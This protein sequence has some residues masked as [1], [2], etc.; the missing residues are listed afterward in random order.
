MCIIKNRDTDYLAWDAC[1][2]PSVQYVVCVWLTI[3]PMAPTERCRKKDINFRTSPASPFFPPS[4]LII[5]DISCTRCRLD[6]AFAQLLMF[7]CRCECCFFRN[8]LVSAPP[9]IRGKCCTFRV[10]SFWSGFSVF[11]WILFWTFVY[12][13]ANPIIVFFC[14]ITL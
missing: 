10:T 5:V 12:T 6:H 3:L 1:S 2:M 4:A 8:R 13:G 9:F 11:V 7:L 14:Q